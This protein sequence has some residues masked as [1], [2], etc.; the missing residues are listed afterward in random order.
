MLFCR[1][2]GNKFGFGA[3]R[4]NE[5]GVSCEIFGRNGLVRAAFGNEH[6]YSSVVG[7]FVSIRV[8]VNI[9]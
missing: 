9:T 7:H 8:L 1:F 4:A 5:G 6:L 2:D 3:Y